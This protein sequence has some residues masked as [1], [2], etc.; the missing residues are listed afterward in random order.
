MNGSVRRRN[1]ITHNII[2]YRLHH[3]AFQGIVL[4][5]NNY[6]FLILVHPNFYAARL[7]AGQVRLGGLSRILSPWIQAGYIIIGICEC[8]S[9]R[10][11]IYAL[12]SPFG[13]SVLQDFFQKAQKQRFLR[14]FKLFQQTAGA[15]EQLANGV[16]DLDEKVVRLLSAQGFAKCVHNIVASV[17]LGVEALI[18]NFQPVSSSFA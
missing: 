15:Q 3:K 11:R 8:E 2:D 18:L 12:D 17:F 14:Q 9:F 7:F 13:Q 4:S 16:P 10:L 1:L 6:V 5:L